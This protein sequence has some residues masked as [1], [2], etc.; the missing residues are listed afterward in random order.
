MTQMTARTI[1]TD[2]F[3]VRK[4][5]RRWKIYPEF[6]WCIEYRFWSSSYYKMHSA[7][8]DKFGRPIDV[9]MFHKNIPVSWLR[10]ISSSLSMGPRIFFKDEP[11]LILMLLTSSG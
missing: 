2:T 11:T 4:L 9:Q 6:N 1:I 3:R 10:D 7:M 5:D 8:I